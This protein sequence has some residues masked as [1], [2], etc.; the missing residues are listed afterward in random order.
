MKN[1]S[2][3][4]VTFFLDFEKCNTNFKLIIKINNNKVKYN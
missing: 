3:L 2:Y 1:K 4:I